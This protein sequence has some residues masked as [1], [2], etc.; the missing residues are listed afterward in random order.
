[1]SQD[2][3]CFHL[4]SLG[5]SCNLLQVR[6][7]FRNASVLGTRW[8]CFRHQ[9]RQMHYSSIENL[10][11]IKS[12]K[13]RSTSWNTTVCGIHIRSTSC[14]ATVQ[15]GRRQKASLSQWSCRTILHDMRMDDIRRRVTFGRHA[16]RSYQELWKG[17]I[18]TFRRLRY[19][20]SIYQS[21]DQSNFS[22]W[23]KT[24]RQLVYLT[25]VPN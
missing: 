15:N 25:H 7:T 18:V 5:T 22:V 17:L 20:Q 14:D 3:K 11:K 9:L 24:D 13:V 12:S 8:C 21:I 23:S 1:M 4:L 6:C 19:H 2:E 10:S 16:V